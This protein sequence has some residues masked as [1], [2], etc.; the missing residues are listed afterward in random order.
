MPRALVSITDKSNL[1][2][3]KP[4]FS[5]GWEFVSTGGTFIAL[6]AVGINPI[7][8]E[9]VTDF[10]EMMSGRLK[11]LH[12]KIFGGILADR[13]KLEHMAAIAKHWM[14]PIDLV[15]VNLYDFAGKPSIEQIDIGGPSLLRAAAKNCKD[16][17]VVC[18]PSHYNHV[19][20][21]LLA[22]NLDLEHRVLLAREVFEQTSKYDR[23]IFDWFDKQIKRDYV[24]FKSSE[25][26]S[27]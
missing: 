4:L 23:D 12:P 11:T 1:A 9:E 3:L 24:A 25:T 18:N 26:V 15:V 14:E 17:V 20:E 13:S 19:V 2:A 10:P 7:A 8:V 5:A 6:E 27:H 21:K 22:G 16:V